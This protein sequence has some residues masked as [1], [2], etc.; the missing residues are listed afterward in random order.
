MPVTLSN[1]SGRGNFRL[2]NSNNS[3]RFNLTSTSSFLLDNYAG[4]SFA[5]S[6]RKLRSAY[7]GACIRVQR[8]SDNTQQDIGFL[9]GFLDT[10]SLNTFVGVGTGTVV[11]WYDQSILSRDVIK[12]AAV[13]APE[14]RISG[15]NQSLN[16]KISVYFNGSKLLIGDEYV[17]G[18]LAA[19]GSCIAFSVGNALDTSTRCML[20]IG[21][22]PYNSQTIRKSGTVLQ[23][24]A[25]NS[26]GTFTDSGNV[27]SGTAQFIACTERKVSSIEIFT[28]TLSNGAT[29]AS[30]TA[31]STITSTLPILGYNNSSAFA[32]NGHIQE[33]ILFALDPSANTTYKT[34]IAAALNSYYTTY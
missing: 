29:A 2:T 11:T 30:G 25:Y 8:S 12:D 23:A 27:S 10:A 4:A 14:I 7:T 1:T 17:D 28:N 13:A 26:G 5:V 6:L 31:N 32:W 34:N 19:N 18:T 20:T 24:I 22:S 3:G 33:V 21:G 15:T 16:S 9:N